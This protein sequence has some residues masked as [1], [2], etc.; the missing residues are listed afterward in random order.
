M[1]GL[2]Q[3]FLMGVARR[4]LL[5]V[6]LIS[7]IVALWY[8]GQPWWALALL[9][10][11]IAAFAY[12]TLSPS[13]QLLGPV[14]THT[15]EPGLLLTFD[16]GPHPS[17]TPALLDLLDEHGVKAVFFLIGQQVQQWP[18]LGREILRRGHT[19]GNHTQ[20]HPATTYW[21]LNPLRTWWE[22]SQCQ[23]TLQREL[24]H[25]ALLFRAPAG[26]YQ[27]FT[28]PATDAL[29]LRI[30]GWTA[31]GYDGADTDVERIWRRIQKRLHSGA[32]VLLHEGRPT[33][34][35]LT[36]RVLERMQKPPTQQ[37]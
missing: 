37:E 22:I 33:C 24:G 26:H 6:G 36:R 27:A 25:T 13:T 15:A 5:R 7:C 11:V 21:A 14:Q 29:D 31:R 8:A 34:L 19:V 12:S 28:H 16:D 1:R 35:P 10:T 20:T 30:M 23:A 3:V 32:I 9:V 4:I 2:P 17:T 18:E